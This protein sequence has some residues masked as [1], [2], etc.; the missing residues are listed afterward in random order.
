MKKTSKYGLMALLSAL[1]LSGCHDR[2]DIDQLNYASKLVV[3]SMPAA[4]DTTL[5]RV[6][7]SLPVGSKKASPP[8][9]DAVIDYRLNGQRQTVENLGDGNYRVV[10]RQKGGDKVEIGV[11]AKGFGSVSASTRIPLPVTISD[12]TS[13]EIR[14]YDSYDETVQNE[15]QLRVT[16]TEPGDSRDYYAVRAV[17]L[18]EANK[19]VWYGADWGFYD[20]RPVTTYSYATI[21]SDSEPVL[22]NLSNIDYDFG[23]DDTPYQHMYLFDDRLINGQ[24]YTLRLN[25][26]YYSRTM[27]TAVELYR[28]TPEYYHFLKS[29][30]DADNSDLA[31]V[32]L[33]VIAPTYSN[34]KGGI[35]YV[36]GYSRQL[37]S[38]NKLNQGQ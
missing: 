14:I 6:T 2:F 29:I 15:L 4:G 18:S 37:T 33:A 11:G 16:F 3:Y 28:L 17:N 21:H 26:P 8:V 23:F 34:V 20:T 19:N 36:G 31:K 32:G 9:T 13:E 30:S 25:I 38:W 24:T 27:P 12:F 5:I 35:G 1:L 7:S 22:K 10:A